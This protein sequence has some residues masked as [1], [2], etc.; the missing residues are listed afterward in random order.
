[1][2]CLFSQHGGCKEAFHRLG[3][4]MSQNSILIDSLPSAC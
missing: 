2:V 4:Q 1:V 3:V